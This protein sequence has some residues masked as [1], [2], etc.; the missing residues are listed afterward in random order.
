MLYLILAISCS[1]LISVILRLSQEKRKSDIGMFIFNYAV[2]ILLGTLYTPGS[3]FSLRAEGAALTL[4]LGAFTGVLF[5]ASFVFFQGGIKKNGLVAASIFM[6]LGVVIPVLTSVLVFRETP[7]LLQVI[8]I[9]LSVAAIIVFHYDKGGL[10]AGSG[11]GYLILLLVISG[12]TDSM[13]NVYSK[14]GNGSYS[15][16]FLLLVFVFAALSSVVLYF[17]RGERM[18]PWDLLAGVVLGIPNYYSS[19]FLLRSLQTV[20][21]VVAY[22]I[23]SVG[24]I[25]VISLVGILAFKETLSRQ[26]ILGLVLV[27]AAVAAL[28]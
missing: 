4:G 19:R 8:G 7:R 9:L 12:F 5:L 15:D 28:A 22:P 20:P 16:F 2:C 13:L 10:G 24:A 3:G 14:V 25:V 6:K 1:S 26:K 18:G 11:L 27:A 23:Y 17:A 21:A